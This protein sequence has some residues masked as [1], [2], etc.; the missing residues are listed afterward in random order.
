MEYSCYGK[1]YNNEPCS[2]T[3]TQNLI[4]NNTGNSFNSF[5]TICPVA[6]C[7]HTA[8]YHKLE[9]ESD[10]RYTCKQ[11]KKFLGM[12][13]DANYIYIREWNRS[14]HLDENSITH[15][16]KIWRDMKIEI[17]QK[18]NV[19]ILNVLLICQAIL[20]TEDII[21]SDLISTQDFLQTAEFHNEYYTKN[22]EIPN[23]EKEDCCVLL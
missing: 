15:A 23:N 19:K 22:N 6:S 11:V 4:K 2:C 5:K 17:R 9:I 21:S 12:N 8:A 18:N 16:L 14:F 10:K 7:L 13:D 20:N 1:T 3:V